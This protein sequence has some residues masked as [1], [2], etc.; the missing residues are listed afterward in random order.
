MTDRQKTIMTEYYSGL[1]L[2]QIADKY[3]VNKSTVL[4]TLRRAENHL[5]E[6]ERVCALRLQLLG[7]GNTFDGN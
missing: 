2:K 3:G 1:S 7:K 6:A 4:R 5:R